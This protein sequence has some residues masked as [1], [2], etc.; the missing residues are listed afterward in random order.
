[1]N[2]YSNKAVDPYALLMDRRRSLRHTSRGVAGAMMAGSALG[3]T[4]HAQAQGNN[5]PAIAETGYGRLQGY[6]EQ[7]ISVFKGIPYGAPTDGRRRFL[8]AID[9][10][11]WPG[12]SGGGE[13]AAALA[14][15]MSDAWISFFARNGNPGADVRRLWS[16]V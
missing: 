14:P 12:M 9:P 5:F 13:Q 2:E 3:L 10:E 16:T 1:M 7:G 11:P 6:M 8:P 15:R 4:G